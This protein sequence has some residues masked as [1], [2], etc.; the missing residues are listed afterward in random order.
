M[1]SK[2]LNILLAD[3]DNDDCIFFDSVL[4]EIPL[5]TH[6]SCVNDGE[7]LMEKLNKGQ[8]NLPDVLYLDLNMPRKNGMDCL[9]EIKSNELLKALPVIMFST[10]LDTEMVNQLY[11]LGAFYFIRK[12]SEFSQL[13]TVIHQSL[14][15]IL[16]KSNI[17]PKRENFILTY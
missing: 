10:S 5:L 8:D 11:K 16:D 12:P 1:N 3:D 6:F 7:L 9:T 4:G 14:L 15:L 13:Q 17:Q 2:P